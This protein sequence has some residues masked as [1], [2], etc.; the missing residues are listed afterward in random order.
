MSYQEMIDKI[1]PE[2]DKIIDFLDRELSKIRTG[3]ASSSLIE[4][5][6]VDCFGQKM[7]LKQLAAISVPEPRQIFIQP[8]DESYIP[9]IEKALERESIG[10]SPV[11]DRKNIRLSM[12]PV[13]EEYRKSLAKVL[14]DKKENARQTVRR[15]RD[16]AW[17][18]IQEA[19]RK[20]DITEDDKFKGKDKLQELVDDYNEKI[21]DKVSKKEKEIGL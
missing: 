15:W 21:E 16:E 4:D 10:A 9:D 7:P 6:S 20:G 3:T 2:M 5:I 8:W 14:A 19:F 13:S 18:E 11:V 1:K 17:K 12:P